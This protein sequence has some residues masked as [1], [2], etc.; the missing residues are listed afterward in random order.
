MFTKN[1]LRKNIYTKRIEFAEHKLTKL[2]Q[3]SL[4]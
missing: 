1:S 3:M 2:S 4:A